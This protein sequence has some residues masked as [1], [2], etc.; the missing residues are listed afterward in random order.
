MNFKRYLV[1]NG[2]EF[3]GKND[4]SL[5]LIIHKSKM[6]IYSYLQKRRPETSD[7]FFWRLTDRDQERRFSFMDVIKGNTVVQ[8]H[9][10]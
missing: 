1:P 2:T 10:T 5:H 8:K 7:V 4:N 3:G 9:P 6:H